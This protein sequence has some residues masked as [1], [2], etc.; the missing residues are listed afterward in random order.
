[1]KLL[2][3]ILLAIGLAA[4]TPALA[5]ATPE[6][7]ANSVLEDLKKGD[8]TNVIENLIA[9]AP[10]ISIGTPEKTNLIN[11]LNT[12]LSSY[13]KVEGWELIHSR[14]AS[15][16]YVEQTYMVFQEKYALH[17]EL[18]LY[19]DSKGWTATAFSFSDSLDPLLEAQSMKKMELM[20]KK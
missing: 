6:T 5:Q 9:K 2:R 1:M 8:A 7:I 11:T 3:A 17:W 13:G 15:D 16:R 20:L 14:E 4:A 19:R 18:K 10:L 12:Y